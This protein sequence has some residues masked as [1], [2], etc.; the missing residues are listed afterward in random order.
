M[1][2]K[3]R[4]SGYAI[5]EPILPHF[6]TNE[7]PAFKIHHSDDERLFKTLSDSF[8]EIWGNSKTLMTLLKKGHSP[9]AGGGK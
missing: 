3:D 7:R 6:R 5:V 8:D 9:P 4:A 2:D 1:V